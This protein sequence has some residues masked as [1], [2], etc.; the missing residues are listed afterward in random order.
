MKSK[1]NLL[2]PGRFKSLAITLCVAMVVGLFGGAAPGPLYASADT[3]SYVESTYSGAFSGPGLTYPDT[4]ITEDLENNKYLKAKLTGTAACELGILVKSGCSLILD[5]NGNVLDQHVGYHSC[6]MI[7]VQEGGQLTIIDTKGGGKILPSSEG[8]ADQTP[9]VNHGELIFDLDESTDIGANGVL[10]SSEQL[11]SN[12]GTMNVKGGTFFFATSNTLLPAFVNSGELTVD[13][14]NLQNIT[15]DADGVCTVNEGTIAGYSTIPGGGITNSGDLTVNGGTI[16]CNTSAYSGHSAAIKNSSGTVV[17]NGGTLSGANAC[18]VTESASDS[19]TINDGDFTSAYPV[20]IA[21][22]SSPVKD[23]TQLTNTTIL[24]GEYSE[25]DLNAN[26]G[27]L[28]TKIYEDVKD[29]DITEAKATLADLL[30]KKNSGETLTEAEEQ[31]VAA[32]AEVITDYGESLTATESNFV[33]EVK[34]EVDRKQAIKDANDYI[35]SLKDI[36]VENLTDE[37]IA[38]LKD[39]VQTIEDNNGTVDESLTE[40]VN[41][42]NE[43]ATKREEEAEEEERKTQAI[44]TARNRLSQLNAKE[45]LTDAEEEEVLACAKTITD[46]GGTLDSYETVFVNKVRKSVEDKAAIA[47]TIADAKAVIDGLKNTPVKNL[48]DAQIEDLKTAKKTVEDNNGTLDET[49]TAFMASVNSEA[50]RRLEVK[51]AKER[52]DE[53]SGKETLTDEEE[54]EVLD[55][56]NTIKEN[57]ETLSN[58][59]NRFVNEVQ[60]E[61]DRK[62]AIN[63]AKEIIDNLK[64]TPVENLTDEQ[65]AELADAVKTISD[66]NGTLDQDQAEFIS[67]TNEEVEKRNELSEEERAKADAIRVARNRMTELLSKDTLSDDEKK[68]VVEQAEII[69]NN[70]G[71]LTV[72]EKRI[73]DG[74][75]VELAKELIEDKKETPV[76]N[77]TDEELEDISDAIKDIEDNE[78]TVPAD[79]DFINRVNEEIARREAAAKAQRIADARTALENLSKKLTLTEAEEQEVLRQAQI[80]TDNGG[81]LTALETR[82]VNEVKAAIEERNNP[83]TPPTTDPTTAPTT[84][85]TTDPTTVPTLLPSAKPTAAPSTKPTVTPAPTKAPV[86]VTVKKP[87]AVKI[88]KATRKNKA[89]KSISVTIKKA[90]NAKGYQIAVYKSLK[91][92]KKNKKE[93]VKKYIKKLKFNLKSKKLA[94]KKTL[95]VRIRAYNLNGKTKVFGNWSKVK[96]IK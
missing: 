47:R 95:Y 5:L 33:N 48:T 31:E 51:A 88:K 32:A 43:E 11:V 80:I 79:E 7:V 82:F 75:K 55:C 53:L 23:V 13:G 26:N 4:L 56:A 74:F 37:Q 44:A 9:I 65:L 85:P 62:Q 90:K 87:A 66:N 15:N 3:I 1:V 71:E 12:D 60:D 39:A 6:P 86:V 58:A 77:L 70:G 57:G 10:G 41:D 89:A 63:D 30:E 8:R 20:A 54:Q 92:A 93:L 49:Q 27:A 42:A 94:N 61:V 24:G 64:D 28:E 18:I 67:D 22:G 76:E 83:T 25:S 72:A 38:N 35:E 50:N 17:V 73:V 52:L 68:E 81:T 46:N 69:V 45:S 14:G 34:Q 40:F 36:P 91:D 59:E 21:N 2:L 16:S 29:R 96:S 84:P 78:E 19:I